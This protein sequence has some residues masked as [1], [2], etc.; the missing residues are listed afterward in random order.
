MK[1]TKADLKTNPDKEI[2]GFSRE[3]YLNVDDQINPNNLNV[4]PSHD[5]VSEISNLGFYLT[6]P[7]IL[8]QWMQL[9]VIIE[10]KSSEANWSVSSITFQV[11]DH[12]P[13]AAGFHKFC[14]TIYFLNFSM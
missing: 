13:Q 9:K 6:I 3:C 10:I 5:M 11:S 14:A 4:D 12:H 1:Y 7:H 8:P 2:E